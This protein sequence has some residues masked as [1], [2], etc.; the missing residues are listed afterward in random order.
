MEC[1]LLC[2]RSKATLCCVNRWFCGVEYL[3]LTISD[4]L[5][6]ITDLEHNS[7]MKRVPIEGFSMIVQLQTKLL[8]N[9]CSRT[10]A[11]EIFNYHCNI[12]MLLTDSWWS[13]KVTHHKIIRSRSGVVLCGC[14]DVRSACFAA[15][16]AHRTHTETART[17]RMYG[18][19]QRHIT[20]TQVGPQLP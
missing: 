13:F 12:L 1:N 6:V 10:A 2:L 5:R 18:S 15:Y 19:C 3:K 17:E 7:S 11:V 4:R 14:T 16:S 9:L 8:R 20:R